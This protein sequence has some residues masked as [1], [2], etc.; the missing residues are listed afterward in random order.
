MTGKLRLPAVLAVVLAAP[1]APAAPAALVGQQPAITLEQVMSAPFPDE[2]VAAPT[3]GALTWVFDARGARNIWVATPPDYRGRQVTAY[4]EDDGQEIAGVEWTPDAKT[5][6]YVRGGGANSRG[7]YPNPTSVAA[8]VEQAVWASAVTGGTPR[9]IG[10]G[11]SPA[12]SPKG[13][14][15]AFI[16]KGQ[17]W[18]AALGDTTPAEQLVHSRGTASTL[19]WSPEGSKLAFVSDRDDH[20]FVGVYDVATKSLRYLDPSVDSDDE[21][22]WSPDGKKVAYLRIPASVG[23]VPFTPRRA[24][25]P[26]SIRVA[27]VAS[28]DGREVWRADSGR[29]S[30]FR[31]I[32]GRQAPRCARVARRGLSRPRAPRRQL[33]PG[34]HTERLRAPREVSSGDPRQP[35]D[36]RC[37]PVGAGLLRRHD[38]QT[39][40]HSSDPL[41]RASVRAAPGSDPKAVESDSGPN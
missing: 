20:G 25:Q 6:V 14:R 4:A 19:R 15:V 35:P 7:E 24:A 11:H 21:P 10:E 32:V 13:D 23:V 30:A 33:P 22:I 1:A 34:H 8:G 39:G 31:G 37:S 28:G 40:S 2:L 38:P 9:K 26:W 27:D 5:I 17:I 3:G 41:C 12:V 16:R 29:G 18:W 36:H